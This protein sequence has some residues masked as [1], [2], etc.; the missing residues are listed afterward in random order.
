MRIRNP[1]LLPVLSL[2]AALLVLAGC[3][4]ID[5][6][7]S[8]HAGHSKSSSEQKYHC[9]MHPTYISDKPGDCPICGMKLVPIP[10]DSGSHE[11]KPAEPTAAGRVG[12]KLSADRRQLIGLTLTKVETRELAVTVRAL[13]IVQHDETRFAR[14]SPRFGGW[15]RKLNVAFT[16]APVEK[17][18][19][20]FTVYSPELFSTESDYLIAWRF[21]QQLKADASGAQR[22]AAKALLEAARMRL[23]LWEIG[24]DEI[25]DLEQRGTA[26]Q[27]LVYRSPL[28]GHVLTKTAVEGK[29]FM[30]GDTLYEVADLSHLWLQASVAETDLPLLAVGQEATVTFSSLGNTVVTAPVTFL[31]PHL[32]PQTRRGTVRIDLD[33]PGHQLRPEM[34]AD[35]E[36][37]VPLG[38][39]LTVPTAA[40]I[41]TGKRYVAFVSMDGDR[42]EP[43]ELKIGAKTNEYYEV[44]EGLKDGEQ[45]VSRALFLIDSESQLQAAIS[46]MSGA[47]KHQH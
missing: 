23:V 1:F 41:D 12:I 22:D 10:A 29:S 16:G 26:S 2:L 40:V 45:V 8:G 7:E 42:L 38:K 15:V 20:L 6:D 9:P 18:Q 4:K 5:H 11:A 36:I 13:A 14:I 21:A 46:G 39:K 24:D 34:W 35:V 33:N 27:E 17:G 44:R 43:R 30:A 37:E 3:S 25:R 32:D 28:S 47:G 31:D 19:P